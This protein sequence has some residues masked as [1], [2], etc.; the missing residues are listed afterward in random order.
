[1]DRVAPILR[2]PSTLLVWCCVVI[3]ASACAQEGASGNGFAEYLRQRD[4]SPP[5]ARPQP[6]A[7]PAERQVQQ[8]F[9]AQVPGAFASPNERNILPVEYSADELLNDP[10]ADVIVEGNDTILSSSILSHIKTR[11]GRP[12]SP[13]QIQ[14]DVAELVKLRWFLNVRPVYRQTE[15]GPVLVFQVTERPIVRSVQ[16][17]GNKKI[18]T[19]ELQANVGLRQGSGFDVS[20]NRES[21]YRIQSMY[22]DKGYRFAKVTLQKGGDPQDRDVVFQIEEGPKVRVGKIVFEGNEFVSGAILK[23]KLA[24]KTAILRFIGG[25]YDPELIQN[26]VLTL[27]QYYTNLGFFEVEVEAKESFSKDNGYVTV[28]YQVSEGPRYRVGNIETVGNV[29]IG[30]GRL[31]NDPKLDEG[32]YFNARFLREDVSSMKEQYDELGRIFAKV[33]PVPQFRADEPGWVD[34]T[35]VVDEDIPRLIGDINVHI[36]GD[37]PH[38]QEEVVLQQMHRFI[39]PGQLA[40]GTNLRMAQQRVMGSQLWERSDPPTFDIHPVDGLDYLPPLVTRGQ[41]GRLQLRDNLVETAASEDLPITSG[42]GHSLSPVGRSAPVSTTVERPIPRAEPE[43]LSRPAPLE[44]G[45]EPAPAKYPVGEPMTMSSQYTIDPEAIINAP[46]ESFIV[47]CQSP[48]EMPTYR[49]QS[50]GRNGLPVPQD[51][52]QTDSPQGDPFGD[53][54]R[55]PATPGFVDVNVDVTEGR[56]GRLM[57]GVGVNSN[58]GV[59]GSIVL[60][61]DNFNLLRPPTSWADIVN[62]TAWRGAGQSFRLEAVPGYQVSRYT[63]SWQDPYFLRSDFSLGLSGFYYNRFFTDWTEDRLGG[64]ISVGRILNQ[65]WSAGLALRLEDVDLHGIRNEAFAPAALVAA[66]GNSLLSTISATAT[67]DTRDSSFMPTRGHFIEGS[68][69]QAFGEYDYSRAE[70][71]AGQFFT[72]Y[73]RPDGYGKHIL[74]FRGQIGGTSS[75]TPIFEKFYAGGYSSFRGFAYRGVSPRQMDYVLGGNWM[76]LATAEYMVPIT[77]SD[78]VRAVVFTDMGTVEEDFGF[79]D[80]RITAG[81]GLRLMI[82]AMGPA[83]LAFDFAWPI[84]SQDFDTERVFSFYIGFTR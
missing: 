74:Q 13:R 70:V 49:G 46:E 61:E 82:P 73:E 72:L 53:A 71:T 15:E 58:A 63:A 78:N 66:K 84:M 1:M 55:N 7:A 67:Y 21:V 50:V 59:V 17:I 31:L 4:Q 29:V 57:F 37:Y 10:L 75:S 34:L 62:G 65:Y 69:E 32:H 43:R 42:F 36:R 14:E 45:F 77:A 27:R 60:Q 44:S 68:F 51:Y 12:P 24:S 3:G 79:N 9:T 48:G 26:D 6:T 54:I 76:A 28:T 5:A 83:P 56:T 81:F 30:T 40:N 8:A 23:T 64:R 11:A 38:T 25:S 2:G 35:Y 20:A 47:R 18:K 16:F 22:Q 19:A 52:M 80:F 39:K 33:E 41:D